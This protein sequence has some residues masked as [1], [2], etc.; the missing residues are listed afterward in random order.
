MTT[1]ETL[2]EMFSRMEDRQRVVRVSFGHGGIYD[3]QILSTGHA[4]ADGDIV[5][6]VVRSVRSDCPERWKTAAMNFN[7]DDVVRVEADDECLFSRNDG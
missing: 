5:A 1:N 4:E 2:I 7:L 6:D 3:L